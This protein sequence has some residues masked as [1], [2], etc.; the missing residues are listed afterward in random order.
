MEQSNSAVRCCAIYTRKSSEEGLEQNFNSLHAQREA[1]ESFIKSQAG[2]GWRLVKT[3]YDDGG[4]SGGTMERPGLQRLLTDVREKLVDVV[5]VYKVDRLTRSLADFAKMV[6]VFDGHG[7]SFVAVTQ[8]FNT[9]TSMGRLTLNVLLSFAQFEREVT[10]E[11]IRDKIAASKKN[12]IWMGGTVPLGYDWCGRRLLVNPA[13]A[14]TVRDIFERYLRLRSVRLLKEELIRDGIVSKIRVSKK[15]DQSGG[16]PFGRGALYELLANPIYVGEVRHRKVRHPGQQQAIVDKAVWEEVQERLRKQAAHHRTLDGKVGSSPLAGKL[17]DENGEPLYACGAN[18]G[19]RRYRYYVS[20]KVVQRSEEK[21]KNGWRLPALEIE[22]AVAT[23]CRQMLGD[24]PAIAANLQEAGVPIGDLPPALEAAKTKGE[25]LEHESSGVAGSLRNLID[26]VQLESRG[27]RVSLNLKRL[28]ADPIDTRDPAS[29][30]MTRFIPTEMKR[31]G[32]ELSLVIEGETPA[33]KRPDPSLLKA[34]ARGHRWFHE[35]ASGRTAS[36][37][38]IA[39]REGVYDSYVRR[40]IPLALLAPDI[41][42]S[43]CDGSQ[44]ATLTAEALK[45]AAP[46]PL[47][48]TKQRQILRCG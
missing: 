1:C 12:G 8:Q 3:A 2:E 23:A 39:R 42:Q 22:R 4:V 38:E 25:Q 33:A 30:T 21:T 35:L 44:P 19:A 29:L 26:R 36:I 28:I 20:R 5:V 14:A 24:R 16:Q 41:V 6:E 18:K 47:E 31:R 37:R 46:L 15:G 48:W 45:H 17:F 43:I 13:E 7:V 40:L 27:I 32:V 10:G 11:R 34:I 9:T